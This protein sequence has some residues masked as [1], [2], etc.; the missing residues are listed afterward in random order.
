MSVN[1]TCLMTG[2]SGGIG[3]A[4]AKALANNGYTL[5]LQGRN[6][7]KLLDV[8]QQISG[9]S[10]IV[11]GDLNQAVDRQHILTEAFSHGPIDLLVNN[12]GVSCFAEF[13]HVEPESISSLVNINLISP[14]LFTQA[15]I[16]Q[17][18]NLESKCSSN[19]INVGSAFGSIGYPGFSIYCASKFGLR[20][21]TEALAREYG[22]IGRAHV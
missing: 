16:E 4:M 9:Q 7:Q 14:M 12:A 10:F 11:I 20:G 5:I 6:E 15:F 22:E 3:G 17:A 8:Q 1:K 18:R 19:I 2:A 13:E 21:F